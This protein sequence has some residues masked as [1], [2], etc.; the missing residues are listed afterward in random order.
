MSD[1]V[2]DVEISLQKH[3]VLPEYEGLSLKVMEDPWSSVGKN[4]MEKL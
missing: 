1:E 3:Y 2:M 4:E